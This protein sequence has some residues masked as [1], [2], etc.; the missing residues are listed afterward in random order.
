ME[1]NQKI[2]IARKN[3]GLTQEQLADLTNITTRTIQR[4]ESGESTP[5][6]YT[7]KTIAAV[8]DISFDDLQASQNR[9]S[10]PPDYTEE[11]G[12]HLLQVICLSCFTYIVIPFIHIL[13]PA[14][15]L[16]KSGEQNPRV[17][18]FARKVI[19]VQLWWKCALWFSMLGALAYNFI[20]AAY[21]QKSYLLNYLWPFFTMYLVN[22]GIII[23]NL[24]QLKKTDLSAQA[25]I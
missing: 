6:S 9:N 24:V 18:A 22:A 20:M 10:P 13:I 11:N 23:Y 16:K 15:I 14:Y 25:A 19:R 4:I 2:I 8:L 12:R 21:F 5:R 17:I 1:L 3:K 7:L